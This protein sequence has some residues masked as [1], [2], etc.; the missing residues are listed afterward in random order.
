MTWVILD[1]IGLIIGMLP[2]S[3]NPIPGPVMAYGQ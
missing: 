3:N 2:D 1:N